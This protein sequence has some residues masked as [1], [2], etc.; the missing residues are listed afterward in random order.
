MGGWELEY[1]AE[2]V[3]NADGSY[4]VA[5]EKQRR[6]GAD[7]EAVQNSYTATAAGKLVLSVDNAASRRRKVAAYRYTVRKSA[8]IV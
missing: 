4:T 7:E 8:A 3:P 1:S 5:V 2:F 6:I